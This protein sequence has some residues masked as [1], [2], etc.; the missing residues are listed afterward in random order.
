MGSRP[1]RLDLT[2]TDAP[3]NIAA[4][5]PRL[6]VSVAEPTQLVVGAT[7]DERRA[8]RERPERLG[9][10]PADLP[11]VRLQRHR[12]GHRVPRRARGAVANSADPAAVSAATQCSPAAASVALRL[13]Q[14]GARAC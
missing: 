11:E 4:L 13:R 8:G 7:F 3:R 6:P 10:P 12:P 14:P 2:V 1:A 9:L 5:V